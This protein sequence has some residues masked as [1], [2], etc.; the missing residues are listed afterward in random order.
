MFRLF[1][2]KEVNENQK[3]K[4]IETSKKS[5]EILANQKEY[6]L[7][8]ENGRKSIIFNY[9][10]KS[11]P[12]ENYNVTECKDRNLE[13][14]RDGLKGW[15]LFY[16]GEYYITDVKYLRIEFCQ[17]TDYGDMYKLY[18]SDTFDLLFLKLDSY[19]RKATLIDD[20]ISISEF[21]IN[22]KINFVITKE[23]EF[24]ILTQKY[25]SE[26]T[27]KK[28]SRF[29]TDEILI[30]D[31]EKFIHDDEL[32]G[33]YYADYY[34][35]N[36]GEAIIIEG[37]E[38]YKFLKRVSGDI[39]RDYN[40]GF[41]RIFYVYNEQ[42]E[43]SLYYSFEKRFIF[44]DCV[45]IEEKNG[46]FEIIKD[47]I[48]IIAM[49]D[50]VIFETSLD[51]K[52][53]YSKEG[54]IIN[55][56]ERQVFIKI[57]NKEDKNFYVDNSLFILGEVL[58][59]KFIESKHLESI[60]YSVYK[61]DNT[62]YLVNTSNLILE[63]DTKYYDDLVD[64]ENALNQFVINNCLPKNKD[65]L[66]MFNFLCRSNILKIKEFRTSYYYGKKYSNFNINFNIEDVKIRFEYTDFF[67]EFTN[68]IY[69]CDNLI[70]YVKTY[71]EE[72]INLTEDVKEK[73][74]LEL[75]KKE[76]KF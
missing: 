71:Y 40:L 23:K 8:E 18:K 48:K 64:E 33:F 67:M 19:V 39:L 12:L 72:R 17:K 60:D 53:S 38:K 50:T 55:E 45:S 16:Y 11:I 59:N 41:K 29:L 31:I 51:A 34:I 49:F 46:L 43:I 28:I 75:L 9:D 76:F 30:P 35:S 36:D 6:L 52:V 1:K 42:N 66:K 74:S 15:I 56:D 61:C 57:I 54:V 62:S 27:E 10:S 63:F 37:G 32:I 5:L 13:L 21:I 2:R 24:V 7:Y 69:S 26:F 73:I 65:L 58:S 70:T 20:C 25:L 47:E 22:R 68:E 4:I 3:N 44:K 14:E